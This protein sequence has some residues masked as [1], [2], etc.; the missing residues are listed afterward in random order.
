MRALEQLESLWE[1]IVV[2]ELDGALALSAGELAEAHG[3]RAGD[4]VQLASA[5]LSRAPVLATWDA[6]LRCAALEAGL[7]VAP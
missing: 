7:A 1:Q 5:L 2:V 3:L 4:A 6:E